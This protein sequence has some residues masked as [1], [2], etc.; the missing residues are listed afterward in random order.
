[1]I[2]KHAKAEVDVRFTTKAQAHEIEKAFQSL[3]PF[4]KGATIEVSGGIN[5]YPLERNEEV[6]HLYEQLKEIA[7]G[8]GYDLQ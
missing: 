1:M 3:T 4:L 8:H 5:R 6:I 2:A 7:A